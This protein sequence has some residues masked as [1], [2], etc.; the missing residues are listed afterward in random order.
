VASAHARNVRCTQR[1]GG[2]LSRTTNQILD[3]AVQTLATAELGL[4]SMESGDPAQR[5]AGLRNVAVFGRA[6]TNVLQNLRSTEPGFDEWYSPFVDE[7]KNDPLLRTFYQLRTQILKIGSTG[8]SVSV[9]ISSLSLPR[10]AAKFGSPPPGATSFF[11]GD[12]LGGTGWEVP[13]PDGSIEKY[14]IDFP[15]EVGAVTVHLA[16]APTTHLGQAIAATD[17]LTLGR[18]Y[19]GYLSSLVGKARARFGVPRGT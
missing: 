17:V 5:M 18:S 13:Q 6:V 12:Q 14:Y 4:A 10:D 15:P 7:M 8:T 9:G 2:G 1:T 3:D 16:A 11:V 19:V